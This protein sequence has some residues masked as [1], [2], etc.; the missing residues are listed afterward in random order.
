MFAPPSKITGEAKQPTCFMFLIIV[1][2]LLAH[3][4]S[5]CIFGR[6]AYTFNR[7]GGL[8]PL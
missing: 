2:T 7:G 6:N 1:K 3:K 8:M 4:T 5:L